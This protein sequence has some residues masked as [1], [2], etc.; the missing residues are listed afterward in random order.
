MAI[1]IQDPLSGPITLTGNRRQ[2]IE[3][4]VMR[5]SI[6]RSEESQSV[7]YIRFTPT[8]EFPYENIV[9]TIDSKGSLTYRWDIP[10]KLLLSHV[11]L[12]TH[13]RALF[14][15]WGNLVGSS[16]KSRFIVT[17]I[18]N[19]WIT[20]P[21]RDFRQPLHRLIGNEAFSLTPVLHREQV[22]TAQLML[23]VD[24]RKRDMFQGF[25]SSCWCTPIW[26][27]CACSYG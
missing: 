3:W 16:F 17:D 12:Q 7:R 15:A 22:G 24:G 21:G 11:L 10:G 9:K 13:F 27:E 2:S 5:D 14:F 26:W 20:S 4:V 1:D 18:L 25:L 6:S 23:N 19:Q 8:K